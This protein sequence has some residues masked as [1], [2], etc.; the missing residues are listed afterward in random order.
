MPSWARSC[1]ATNRLPDDEK[2]YWNLNTVTSNDG[3][4]AGSPNATIGNEPGL[5]RLIFSSTKP[6]AERLKR[7]VFN[8][9][10]QHCAASRFAPAAVIDQKIVRGQLAIV[11]AGAVYQRYQQ[12]SA[13]N[14]TP[15]IM[16]SSL[17]KFLIGRGWLSMVAI[18]MLYVGVLLKPSAAVISQ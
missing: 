13:A 17:S 5:Y 2:V 1:Q 16:K 18:G 9:V 11:R 15:Y 10:F 7:S 14:N 4:R 6:E 8:K 12:W 3:I